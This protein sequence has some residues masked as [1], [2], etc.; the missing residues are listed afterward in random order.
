MIEY[1]KPTIMF[2]HQRMQNIENI[3]TLIYL[4]IN[5]WHFPGKE[6][7][8]KVY[9]YMENSRDVHSHSFLLQFFFFS[10]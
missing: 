10:F 9:F 5:K 8:Q 1:T 7:I 4:F 6:N 2:K 3:Y